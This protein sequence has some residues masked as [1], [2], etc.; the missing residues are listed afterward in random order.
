M[1][2]LF[3]QDGAAAPSGA[4]PLRVGED[5]DTVNSKRDMKLENFDPNGVGV[6]NGNYF[7]LPITPEEADLVLISAPWDVT[8]SYGSGTAF[9][10]DAMIEASTQLDLYDLAAP[11]CWRRGIATAPVDYT[12]QELSERLRRDAERVIEHLEEGGSVE[13]DQVVRKLRRVNEGCE[14]MNRRIRE[15]A[16]EWLA[17]G[18]LVGLVGGDH[19]TPYGLIS[20]LAERHEAFGVLHI[21]AHCDLRVAYEG[22]E[23]SHASIMHNILRDLPQVERLV[24]VGVRDFC[25]QEY[26]RAQSDPRIEMF[27]DSD[28]AHAAFEGVLWQEQCRRIVEKLPQKVYISFDIDGLSPDN[29]PH[30]GTPVPGG[31]SF[32]EALYLL[33]QVVRSGRRIIGFDVVEVTP[34][35]EERIDEIV[36]ARILYRLCNLALYS[37][38]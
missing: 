19:S 29:C 22:F 4:L 15:Q 27:N 13:D 24:E 23:Y 17:Q 16:E 28:L 33:E 8:V 26:Q 9:A 31:L 11:D 34:K 25:D 2:D 12:L 14:E 32:R 38:E 35:A 6:D 36:G 21:D 30:T 1:H 37:N 5:H 18:K 7:G 20:A 3:A 10:P